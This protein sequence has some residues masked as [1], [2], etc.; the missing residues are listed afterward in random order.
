MLFCQLGARFTI[1]IFAYNVKK[2]VFTA[3]LLGARH[4]EEVVENKQA[5]SLVA[6]FGKVLNGTPPPLMLKTSGPD[7]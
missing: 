2:I 5:S 3:S 1:S 4:L 7:A 6:S